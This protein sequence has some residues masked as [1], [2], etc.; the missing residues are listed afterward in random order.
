M[1]HPRFLS[2]NGA[3]VPYADAKVHIQTPLARYGIGVFEGIVAYW[4][5]AHQTSYIFRLDD[6]LRRLTQSMKLM[7]MAGGPSVQE[8]KEALFGLIRANEFRCDVHIRLLVWIDGDG[9]MAS[10]GPIGWSI[11]ALARN[12][13]ST[14]PKGLHCAVSSWRRIDDAVMPPRIKAVA[15]YA[16]GRLALMQARQDGYDT[17]FLM[18]GAGHVT[19][20]PASCFFIVR[21]GVLTTPLATDNILES[22]TRATILELAADLDPVPQAR[23]ID[24]TELYIAEEVFLCGS[25]QEV[26]PVVSVDRHTI[27]DG[28]V[29]PI[30]KLVSERYFN[31]ARGNTGEREDWR[32]PVPFNS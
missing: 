32:A 19:E 14:E 25:G 20:T 5:D 28:T 29:G 15:N 1:A 27:G 17:A 13:A 30:T 16:Q 9:D 12:R 11:T 7:R 26:S 18:N 8:M 4:N 21:D 2:L 10:E 22:V 6:H 3:I 31:I 23:H 24:R